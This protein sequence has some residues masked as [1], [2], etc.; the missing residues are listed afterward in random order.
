MEGRWIALFRDEAGRFHATDDA[1][2][3]EGTSLGDGVLHEG[4]VICPSHAWV[5]DVRTGACL[6]MPGVG[7]ACYAT[8]PSGADVEIELPDGE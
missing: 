5:F 4:R 6:N 1:C 3:H 8:R 2:P 7:V